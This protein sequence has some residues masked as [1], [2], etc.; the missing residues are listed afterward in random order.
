MPKLVVIMGTRLE[1]LWKGAWLNEYRD[2]IL[3]GI[4]NPEVY[5]RGRR[6]HWALLPKQLPGSSTTLLPRA[7]LGKEEQPIKYSWAP[8]P[9]L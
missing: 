8:A 6:I 5:I 3:E 7:G 1:S 2:V 4:G 9:S